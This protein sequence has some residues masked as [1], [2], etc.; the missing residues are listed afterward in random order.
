[1]HSVVYVFAIFV[2]AILEDGEVGNFECDFIELFEEWSVEVGFLCVREW[3][4]FI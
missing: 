3:I 4:P 2:S 1:M